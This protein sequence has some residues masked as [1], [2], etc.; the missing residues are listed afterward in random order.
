MAPS[1]PN[2]SAPSSASTLPRSQT[3]S[4]TP[5]SPPDWRSTAPGTVKIPE[6]IVVPTTMRTRSRSV[7]TRASCCGA[8]GADTVR[9][10]RRWPPRR[11]G[12]RPSRRYPA[13]APPRRASPVPPARGR[14]PLRE[15]RA[16]RASA[17]RRARPPSGWRSPCPRAAAPIH[18][19]ART[20]P[21]LP[22]RGGYWR[23]RRALA[24]RPARRPGRTGCRRTGC[25]SRSPGALRLAYQLHRQRVH[26]AVLGLDRAKLGGD[27]LERF[28]PNPV[29]WHGVRFVAHRNAGLAVILR[30]LEGGADDPLH[31]L[32]R[33]DLFG[34]VLIAADV[35]P[36]EI[37]PFGVLTEDHEVDTPAVAPQGSEVGMEQ[38]HGTKVDVQIEAEPES[39]QD[40]PCVLVV[41]Y[42]R[43]ADRAEQDGVRVVAQ[44]VERL[45]GECFPGLEVVIGAVRQTLELE[46]DRVL[47][48]RA[49]DQG[50][51][52]LDH[53]GADP[54]PRNHRDP[55]ASH[56]KPVA[57][58]QLTQ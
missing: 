14:G 28:L 11:R 23:W 49:V 15:R 30:P 57:R 53:F 8:A 43:V 44:L 7:S 6:P 2:V 10:A 16:A 13:S 55:A 54:V 38:R 50:D 22:D 32:R 42:A 25:W 36:A 24:R 4:A 33:V 31:A 46:R 40:V 56:S 34:H 1:S 17:R 20:T 37:H 39:Q 12:F 26:V 45:V 19:P 5:R 35:P 47:R 52:R 58:P 9:A 18:A 21:L 48:R 29:S 41:R 51:R 27:P 3:S